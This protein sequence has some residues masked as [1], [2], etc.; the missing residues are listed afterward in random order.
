MNYHSFQ[1][2]IGLEQ[3]VE[4]GAEMLEAIKLAKEKD[5]S[6]VLCD[7]NIQVTLQRAWRNQAFGGD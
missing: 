1:K 6:F 4:P 7:R 2:K 5:I 3:A